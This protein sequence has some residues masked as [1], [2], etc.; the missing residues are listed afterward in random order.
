[1]WSTICWYI[2]PLIILA[3]LQKCV[4]SGHPKLFNEKGVTPMGGTKLMTT[5]NKKFLY[6]SVS[7]L[8]NKSLVMTFSGG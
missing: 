5:G 3:Q 8:R 1:M 4:N 2:T 6:L 7:K